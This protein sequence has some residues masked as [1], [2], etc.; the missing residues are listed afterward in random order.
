MSRIA[1][2]KRNLNRIR[3]EIEK[4]E[5]KKVIA[6]YNI[7]NA[8][9]KQDINYYI[10]RLQKSTWQHRQIRKHLEF[11]R[12]REAT[13]IAWLLVDTYWQGNCCLCCSE[14]NVK[15]NQVCEHYTNF[16]IYRKCGGFRC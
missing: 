14:C 11:L 9:S 10:L 4:Y 7:Q 8:K 15:Q 3:S 2:A 5:Q 6:R 16:G 1:N 13:I 12:T